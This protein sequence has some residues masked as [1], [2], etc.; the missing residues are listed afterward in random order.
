MD[1][2]RTVVKMLF[3]QISP[4]EILSESISYDKIDDNNLLRLANVYM[5]QYSNDEIKNMVY[6]LANEFEWYHNKAR[7]E[8]H[9]RHSFEVNVFDALFVLTANLL[10]EENGCP[11]CKYEHLLRWRD[12]TLELDEDL[13]VT[14]FLAYRD[15]NR[16]K[17][18]RDF[19]WPPVIGHNNWMLNRMLEQG[20]AENHFHLKGSAPLFHLSWIS[21]MND[22]CNPEFYKT[23]REYDKRRLHQNRTYNVAY[24]QEPLTYA[25]QQAVLVRLFLYSE[26]KD[27]YVPFFCKYSKYGPPYQVLLYFLNHIEELETYLEDI[28]YSLSYLRSEAVH[29]ALDYT[30][31]EQWL[32]QNPNQRLNEVITGERYFLYSMF[33]KIYSCNRQFTQYGNIFYLYIIVKS[34]IRTE[35]IQSNQNVGFDNFYLYQMR[36]EFFIDNTPFEEIYVR[37][38]VR[39]TI[40]N[41]HISKLEARIAPKESA[42]ANKKYIDRL[43]QWIMRNQNPEERQEFRNRFFYVFHFV[44]EADATVDSDSLIV[45]RHHRKREEVKR[46]AIE[47]AEF[48]SR[49]ANTMAEDHTVIEENTA[50]RLKGIDACNSEIDCRPEVFAQA[51]RFLKDQTVYERD[52]VLRIYHSLP[53]LGVTY[54]VGEDNY[55]IV[56]GLRAIDE[57]ISFLNMRC[58]DRLGHALA[59]GMDVEDWYE[60]KAQRILIPAMNYLDNLAWMHSKIRRF[61]LTEC[62]DAVQFIE[63]RY[64]EYFRMIYLNNIDSDYIN[65]VR[66]NAFHYFSEKEISNNYMNTNF[67]FTINTY[68]DSWKLRGDNPYYFKRGY[69]RVNQFPESQWDRYGVNKNFPDNYRVR[70]N[71]EAAL[72][73]HLYHYSPQVREAGQKTLEIKI[74]P[75]LI[76]AAKIIQKKMQKDIC[77]KGI[78]IETN[79]SSNFLIGSFK[80]YD[81]HPI[82][83]WFNHGLTYDYAKLADCPQIQVSINT[84]DQGVFATYLENEYAL[85][86]LALEK[87]KKDDGTQVYNRT[88]V[89]HWLNHIRKMGL[90]QSFDPM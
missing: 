80:R 51:F 40:L 44:K 33:K 48:R 83:S 42:E 71:P 32:D 21:M 81:K 23:L 60:G 76:K 18:Q 22:V 70:Y 50:A 55:D 61:C 7:G 84:D 11:F 8:E 63:K 1:N 79:P 19:F 78:A 90:A 52:D 35:M 58:G 34:N 36:K 57:A 5:P 77:E 69:F 9:S 41:Q 47:I 29:G 87:M 73:Y 56:D 54:H 20:I 68:Y 13:M 64:D 24:P 59:L 53:N 30:I 88:M 72:L 49:Y 62:N 31:D 4:N 2:L 66:N 39:D 85:L 86:S 82:T 27:K 65:A 16:T 14:A 3:R 37:M 74:N 15:L 89:C 6:F 67:L 38:A 25:Y 43:D 28:Q 10:I 17:I 75:A 26:L 12:V 45:P 46:K